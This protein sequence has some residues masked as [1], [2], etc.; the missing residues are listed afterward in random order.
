MGQFEAHRN[1]EIGYDA[2]LNNG[3]RIRA[4]S[5]MTRSAEKG[6]FYGDWIQ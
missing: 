4:V 6:F 1:R 3:D 5:I 2:Y